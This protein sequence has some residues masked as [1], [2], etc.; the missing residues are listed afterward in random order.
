MTQQDRTMDI[1]HMCVKPSLIDHHRESS[2]VWVPSESHFIPV[3]KNV[4]T[5]VQTTRTQFFTG[6][7]QVAHFIRSEHLEIHAWHVTL[8]VSLSI[9]LE[10]PAP[11]AL[12]IAAAR[13]SANSAS[14]KRFAPEQCKSQHQ[15]PH[16]PQL[17]SGWILCRPSSS[18][19]VCVPNTP[20][21]TVSE[22]SWPLQMPTVPVLEEMVIKNV[23]QIGTCRRTFVPHTSLHFAPVWEG[24]VACQYK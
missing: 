12:S 2:Q 18:A 3:A 17:D 23:L 5:P 22:T 16:P 24:F 9:F 15:Q 21:S 13:S 19:V 1:M 6:T 11:A 7:L 10:T 14:G 4:P 20:E 8:N